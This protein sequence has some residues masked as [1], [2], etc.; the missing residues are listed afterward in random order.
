[1]AKVEANFHG[2]PHRYAN[3]FANIDKYMR[4]MGLTLLDLQTYRY[5]RS[6]LP[7]QFLYSI[8]AQTI[9]GQ[10]QWGDAYYYRD[11]CNSRFEQI[12]NWSPNRKEVV[13]MLLLLELHG[14]YDVAVE[15]LI[16]KCRLLDLEQ[17]T[18]KGLLDMIV[19]KTRSR[20][21]ENYDDLIGEFELDH[22]IF[23]P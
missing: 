14:F 3:N 10:I 12:S 1:M 9:S 20:F 4:T 22:T 16:Q 5:S 13:R 7:D 17:T 23:Y 6:A 2:D 18:L 21:A 15:L 8:P 11:F 19:Q